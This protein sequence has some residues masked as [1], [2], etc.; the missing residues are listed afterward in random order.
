MKE[1]DERKREEECGLSFLSATI[2]RKHGYPN[3]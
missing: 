2:P 1:K 3:V